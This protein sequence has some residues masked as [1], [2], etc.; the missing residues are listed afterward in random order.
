M[1]I[2]ENITVTNIPFVG[3]VTQPTGLQTEIK[4]RRCFAFT[5]SLGGKIIYTQ[6]EETFIS[7]GCVLLLHPHGASYTLKCERGGEFIVIDFFATRFFTDKFIA[8]NLSRPELF[9]EHYKAL[10]D[11][12]LSGSRSRTLAEF[13]S[14]IDAISNDLSVTEN[15]ILTPVISYLDENFIKDDISN[16]HLAEIAHVSESYLRR[17]FLKT[18]SQTPRQY[19]ISLRIRLAK[20]LLAENE[21][22]VGEI[23]ERCGFSSAFHFCRSFKAISG[24]TPLSYAKKFRKNA[25]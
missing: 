7:D 3:T 22:T 18:Y 10:R 11:A 8:F 19:V 1:D 6:G 24:E 16:S 13:Y 5:L 20:R 9:T 15:P 23:S 25:L 14:L 4:K 21:L 2:L 12:H 17:L